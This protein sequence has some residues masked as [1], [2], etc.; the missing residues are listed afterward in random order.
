[1]QTVPKNKT[2]YIK[3]RRFIEGEALPPFIHID[4]IEEMKP[5]FKAKKKRRNR[6]KS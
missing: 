4:S 3:A 1:M 5:E 6:N 2:V